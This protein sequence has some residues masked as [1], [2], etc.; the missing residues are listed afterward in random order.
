MTLL[1]QVNFRYDRAFWDTRYYEGYA[2]GTLFDIENRK[3]VSSTSKNQV[4]E[5]EP[6]TLVM[7]PW[8]LGYPQSVKTL[9]K[10]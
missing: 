4:K 10:R 6:A 2:F 3:N 8:P 7:E 1:Q 5:L 9:P